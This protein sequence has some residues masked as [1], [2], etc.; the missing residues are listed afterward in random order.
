MQ[1]NWKS[2]ER[3]R[4]K[5]TEDQFLLDQIKKYPKETH[6]DLARKIIDNPLVEGRTFDAVEQRIGW[7]R[8]K[9]R[10]GEL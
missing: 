8:A 9:I 10:R 5:A 6:M 4:W 1:T 3:V 2:T 7:M